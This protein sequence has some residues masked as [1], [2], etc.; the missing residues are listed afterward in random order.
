[1]IS[2]SYLGFAHSKAAGTIV[3]P[4]SNILYDASGKQVIVGGLE[5]ILIWNV[6]QGTLTN[7]LVIENKKDKVYVSQLCLNPESN[8]LA[9]GYSDGSICIWDLKKSVI[10]AKFNGHKS[11]I[12]A[13]CFCKS[14]LLVSGSR[15]TDIIFWDIMVEQGLFKLRGHKNAITHLKFIERTQ[16][17]VSS[18]KDQLLKLWDI[19]TRHCVQTFSSHPSEIWSFDINPEETRLVTLCADSVLRFFNIIDPETQKVQKTE[20]ESSLFNRVEFMGTIPRKGKGAGG[21][22]M[23]TKFTKNGKLL[24]V[25]D[26]TILEIFEVHDQSK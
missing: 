3:V 21:P 24:V 7:S 10:T 2:K 9:A 12:T 23:S 4:P 20:E 19:P 22:Y 8:I 14:G 5:K 1:M 18:S 17:L 11:E 15:D 6:R 16:T 13:L 26:G 25:E